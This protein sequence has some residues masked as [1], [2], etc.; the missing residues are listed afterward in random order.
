M[1]A[2]LPDQDYNY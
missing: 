1:Q 2:I